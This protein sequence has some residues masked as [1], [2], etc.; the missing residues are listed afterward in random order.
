MDIGLFP[1]AQ[2]AARAY[3]R[4]ALSLFGDAA[5]CNFPADEQVEVEGVATDG[6]TVKGVVRSFH[7]WRAE[8]Q[9]G[10]KKRHLGFFDRL[11]HASHAYNRAAL[12]ANGPETAL[13]PTKE[14][15]LPPPL[16]GRSVRVPRNK[17]FVQQLPLPLIALSQVEGA[18]NSAE[19]ERRRQ[20]MQGKY[21]VPLIGENHQVSSLPPLPPPSRLWAGIRPGSAT[22]AR[23]AAA[24]AGD[25]M[26]ASSSP[27]RASVALA[28][29]ELNSGSSAVLLPPPSSKLP[30]V[31]EDGVDVDIVAASTP[32]GAA[33]R[34][35]ADSPRN[36]SAPPV[37]GGKGKGPAKAVPDDTGGRASC[38]LPLPV[39][40]PLA[41]A[42][43]G[44]GHRPAAASAPATVFA[45]EIAPTAGPSS[46]GVAGPPAAA[47]A[48]ACSQKGP[49]EAAV[50]GSG[51]PPPVSEEKAAATQM[52]DGTSICDIGTASPGLPAEVIREI[53]GDSSL[54]DAGAS[55]ARAV[56]PASPTPVVTE[57]VDEGQ[58][59][60]AVA[61][62]VAAAATAT[63]AAAAATA[64]AAAAAVFAVADTY[65]SQEPLRTGGGESGTN[66]SAA[67]GMDASPTNRHEQ[68]A[69]SGE[70]SGLP[71]TGGYDVEGWQG[72][73]AA[74]APSPGTPAS[75][76]PPTP[77]LT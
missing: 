47:V 28:P 2:A 71:S 39:A 22:A 23:E 66:K 4:K 76:P 8:M 35:A 5:L 41:M 60:V 43:R 74:P 13:N 10:N 52:A 36:A 7:Q 32:D 15:Y 64:T 72:L 1:T 69:E 26:L 12:Y 77:V 21:H 51:G 34:S 54:G 59:V 30:S 16:T 42:S 24:A 57:A 55:A 48:L 27:R 67:V 65:R 73:G 20:Q 33:S 14:G 25:K 75:S 19:Y 46:T 3:D 53:S 62:A 29:A 18:G 6:S 61:T 37:A 40:R 63:A 68:S 49:C 38:C 45:T 58:V 11:D 50:P 44:D 56:S 17:L 9:W 70:I 31:V